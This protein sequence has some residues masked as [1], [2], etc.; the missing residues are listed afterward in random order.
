MAK[1]QTSKGLSETFL[2]FFFPFFS[3]IRSHQS[4]E[5]SYSHSVSP[6]K[7]KVWVLAHP[8]HQD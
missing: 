7:I 5:A 6:P 1:P 4:Y 2:I 8:N 3:F